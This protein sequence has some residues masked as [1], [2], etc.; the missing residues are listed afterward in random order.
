MVTFIITSYNYPEYT[1]ECIKSIRRNSNV[2]CN[3]IIVDNG[4]TAENLQKLRQNLTPDTAL[5]KNPKNCWLTA[6]N[7][8]ITEG[9]KR[10]ADF[11]VCIDNDNL[12]LPDSLKNMVEIASL[13]NVGM[14]SPMVTYRGGAGWKEQTLHIPESISE[15]IINSMKNKG[16]FDPSPL[17]DFIRTHYSI[18]A[19]IGKPVKCSDGPCILVTR[20]AVEK[21]GLF[22]TE[23]T[24]AAI[25]WEADYGLRLKKAGLFWYVCKDAYVFHFNLGSQ[26]EFGGSDFYP[27]NYARANE[28]LKEK[29]SEEDLNWIKSATPN[30]IYTG[31]HDDRRWWQ[32]HNDPQKLRELIRWGNE[33]REKHQASSECLFMKL[34]SR[35]DAIFHDHIERYR[36]VSDMIPDCYSTLDVGCGSGYG[37]L[38]LRNHHYTGVDL[39]S[40]A[41]IFAQKYVGMWR[42]HRN[43]ICSNALKLP[44]ANGSFDSVTCFECIEHVDHPALLVKEIARVLKPSRPAFISTPLIQEDGGMHGRF[45]KKEFSFSQFKKL[46][47][48]IGKVKKTW[49]QSKNAVP[50]EKD[51]P[52]YSPLTR[53][54]TVIN[55]VEK[56]V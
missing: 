46:C 38:I 27:R 11:C 30:A 43:F 21:V 33:I 41:V 55:L 15:N 22:D 14:V 9:F 54:I 50:A 20:E 53:T 29:Y 18:Y 5:I 6:R 13:P 42:D 31:G 3:I 7:I 36:L 48:K 16:K 4:S 37:G 32:A 12:L 40:I 10:G 17:D 51:P 35:W 8:G 28:H 2:L 45:H 39:S 44:F 56:N 24:E 19:G 49:I 47:Q 52:E 26:V 34:P 25:A 23:L 1:L